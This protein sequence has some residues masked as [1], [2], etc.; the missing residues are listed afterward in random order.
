M[1]FFD[2]IF[3]LVS[4]A[5][6]VQRDSYVI[7]NVHNYKYYSYIYFFTLASI[8]FCFILLAKRRYI[9]MLLNGVLLKC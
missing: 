3:N 4:I 7:N 2:N 9:K 5:F 6:Y 8:Q 1:L